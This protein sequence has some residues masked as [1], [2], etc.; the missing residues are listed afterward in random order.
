MDANRFDLMTKRVASRRAALLAGGLGIASAVSP[1]RRAAAQEAT[2]AATG[3]PNEENPPV[4]LFLQVFD[5]GSWAPKPGEEGTYVLTLHGAAAQTVFFSDRPDR[6]VGQV[7]M[8]QFLDALG[9]TPA[10]PPNAA[11]VAEHGEHG[12]EQEI[13]IIELLNPV[14]D[15]ATGTLTYDAILLEDYSDDGLAHLAAQ[16]RDGAMSETFGAGSLFIDD[17][18]NG[19]ATCTIIDEEG[20]ETGIGALH[21]VPCCW[22]SS[23]FEC[24]PC[25][26]H[27]D[28][29][30]YMS[31]CA[32]EYPDACVGADGSWLCRGKGR[33]CPYV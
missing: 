1:W 29:D 12:G 8:Q 10:N 28:S 4:F 15:A 13:L 27:G 22:S 25:N 20:Y 31:R 9:F 17:C 6:I 5:G 26:R 21:G 18:P 19:M 2:P 32:E 24:R 3:A 7:P 16:Q 23:H 30:Y 33:Y 14:Y 11:L